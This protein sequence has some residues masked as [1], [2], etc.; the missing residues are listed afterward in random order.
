M[1]NYRLIISL[2]LVIFLAG[3][4]SPIVI[5]ITGNPTDTPESQPQPS[6]GSP[7]RPA[8]P[9]GYAD[10]PMEATDVLAI[11]S[12]KAVLVVGPIDGAD[13]SWTKTEVANMQLAENE[14]KAYGINVKAYYPP[15]DN[16][17]AIKA[18][19]L[20]AQFFYYRGHGVSDSN[21]PKN[22]GGLWLTSGYVSPDDIRGMRLAKGAVVMM[23]GCYMAGSSSED[24]NLESAEARRRIAQYSEPFITAG[25]SSYYANWFGNAF[26]AFT[27]YLFQ[28]KTLLGAYQAY[29]DYDANQ[30]EKTTHPA[31]PALTLIADKDYWDGGNKYDNAFV[32]NPNVTLTDLFGTVM[33]AAPNPIVYLATNKSPAKATSILVNGTTSLSFNW[34][35]VLDTGTASW[36]TLSSTSGTSGSQATVTLN[37]RGLATGTYTATLHVTTTTPGVAKPDQDVPIKLDIVPELHEVFIPMAI[38]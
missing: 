20:G 23:Y 38:K 15:N 3:C 8:N 22:V 12:L 32:G 30:A 1:K 25:A 33:Q 29:F 17:A 2:F 14:L 6:S 36:V 16:W 7:L 24:V 28:G 37:P 31:F 34:N 11:P 18:D 35:A 27:R 9:L 10:L 5:P 26:Q 21:D 13:G 19:A 4:Y